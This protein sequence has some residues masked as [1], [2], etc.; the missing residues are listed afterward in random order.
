VEKEQ[1]IKRLAGILA[2]YGENEEDDDTNL[3]IKAAIYRDTAR[4]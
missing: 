1:A 2:Y 3:E 4:Y